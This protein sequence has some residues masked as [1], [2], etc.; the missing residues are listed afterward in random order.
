MRYKIQKL[1][2][3]F[4]DLPRS[5]MSSIPATPHRDSFEVSGHKENWTLP[6]PPEFSMP[7]PTTFNMVP[8]QFLY[9]TGCQG[10][11]YLKIVLHFDIFPEDSFHHISTMGIN[12]FYLKLG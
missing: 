2:L 9:T 12:G 7:R 8:R 10:K 3:V 5:G 4:K 6:P 11:D 1:Y